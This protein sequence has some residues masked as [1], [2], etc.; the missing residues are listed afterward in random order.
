MGVKIKSF[1]AVVALASAGLAGA[2]GV[3]AATARPTVKLTQPTFQSLSA[4][5]DTSYP[6]AWD[7]SFTLHWSVTAPAGVCKQTL[8][9]QDYNDLGGD[10]DPILG[11]STATYPLSKTARSYSGGDGYWLDFLRGGYGAVIRVTDCKGVKVASNAVHSVILPGDDNDAAMTYA[12]S[13]W[14]I[15]NCTCFPGGTAH[16]TTTKNASITFRTAKPADASGVQLALIMP[17]GP[18]RGSAALYIDNKYKATIN[19]YKA[20]VNVNGTIV[21]Q[22]PLPGTA[23]HVV[24][25]VNLATA[26]H[27]RIDLDATINGG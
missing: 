15:A 2:Q 27:P 17:K 23:T 11:G 3:S 4:Y 20:G 8:T 25:L 1:V 5:G 10:T 18:T 21:Y 13:G 19:T 22:V 14:R 7:V 9:D 24:K 12:G 16:Y 6:M 26:G